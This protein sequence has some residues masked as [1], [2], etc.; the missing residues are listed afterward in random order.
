M[1]LALIATSLSSIGMPAVEP[2][3]RNALE[4]PPMLPPAQASSPLD[5]LYLGLG[6]GL[7][8]AHSSGGGVDRDLDD[9]VAFATDSELD[10][11]YFGW[12]LVAGYRFAG[13]P[14]S[15]ELGYTDLGDLD[16]EVLAAPPDLQA[17]RRQI[18]EIHPLSGKGVT[19]AGSYLVDFTER[20]G[21][22]AKLGGWWWESTAEFDTI[23][24][25]AGTR[26]TGRVDADG[27]D[28]LFGLGAQLDVAAGFS[29]R[30]DW[31]R[32]FLDS[33]DVDLFT[34]GVVYTIGG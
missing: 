24:P 29:L 13:G 7:T 6:I 32:Y 8:D 19:L 33:D 17:F 11:T 30:A 3:S 22:S 18:E 34:V 5:G 4:A 2:P 9:L 27:I 28:L 14:W 1:I 21:A 20:I 31:E 15:V 10:S 25:P 12:R 23:L 16:S 26:S